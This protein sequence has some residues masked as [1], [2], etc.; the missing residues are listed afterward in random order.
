MLQS[1]STRIGV[2]IAWNPRRASIKRDVGGCVSFSNAQ[3]E[4]QPTR[5][6]NDVSDTGKRINLNNLDFNT[7]FNANNRNMQDH[8]KTMKGTQHYQ[9]TDQTIS[10][11]RLICK[12]YP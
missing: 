4:A 3:K 5:T 11:S 6:P 9:P 1:C 10:R 7:A 8:K 12:F 2:Y